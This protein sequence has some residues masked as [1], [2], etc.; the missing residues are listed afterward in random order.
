MECP[1]SLIYNKKISP[2]PPPP[3][4]PCTRGPLRILR[5]PPHFEGSSAFRGLLS[6]SGA[7][8]HFA[9]TERPYNSSLP[10]DTIIRPQRTTTQFALNVHSYC[11][12]SPFSSTDYVCISYIIICSKMILL[13][14]PSFASTD[15]FAFTA[16]IV[17][18]AVVLQYHP[19]REKC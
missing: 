2:L 19:L 5:A 10:N 8:P 14:P 4:P 16:A 18:A 12:P 17:V 15:I 9:P 1:I 7:P 11:S 3:P 6:I 13:L